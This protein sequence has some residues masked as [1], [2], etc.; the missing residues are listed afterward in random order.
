MSKI[1]ATSSFIQQAFFAVK[2]FPS[3]PSN[4][5]HQ[6]HLL[7]LDSPLTDPALL[8]QCPGPL[9]QDGTKH[10]SPATTALILRAHSIY[11][12]FHPIFSMMMNCCSVTM[13]IKPQICPALP[14]PIMTSFLRSFKEYFAMLRKS[15]RK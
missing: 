4:Q 3:K 2:T 12:D 5:L 15:L 1:S 13:K 9:E 6:H 7:H 11:T 8:R 10:A 14:L